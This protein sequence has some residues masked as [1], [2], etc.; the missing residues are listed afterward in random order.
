MNDSDFV[1]VSNR[2]PVDHVVDDDGIAELEHVARRPRHGPRAGHAR[3]RRR[4]GRLGRPARPRPRA[5]RLGRHPDRS[6]PAQRRRPR[7]LTTR[8]SATTPSGR[9]TTTSSRRPATTGSGGTATSASTSASPMPPPRSARPGATVWVQD[10]QLQLVPQ[11]LRAARPDLTIGF[12]NHIPFPAYGIFSQ[13]PWRTQIIE[14]LLGAD[15][16]RLP[17][18]GGRR[19]LLARG[20]PPARL[21]DQE[22]D[23]RGAGDGRAARPG[24]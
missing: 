5:V 13:L 22:P 3:C 4:L 11:M 15:V 2:L 8:A 1:V 18:R 14:G 19:Q 6:G 24:G 9:C 17:A 10:Y 7:E 21:L 12:F 16:D 20:A 23:H